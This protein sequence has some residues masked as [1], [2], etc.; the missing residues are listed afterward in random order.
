M[1]VE[2]IKD[3]IGFMREKKAYWLAP[4]IFILVSF[5]GLILLTQGSVIAPFIYALF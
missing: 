2:F 3:L 5:I 1:N 4:V